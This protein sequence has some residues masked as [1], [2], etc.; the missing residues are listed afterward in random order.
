MHPEYAELPAPAH[1]PDQARAMLEEA[2][3][4]ET[5]IELTSISGDWRAV[6]SDAIASQL[7]DAG[8]KVKR[9]V[10]PGAT[11]WNNWTKYPFSTTDWGA[12]PL[13]VQVYALAYKSDSAWNE[14]GHANP[15]FDAKLEEAM[16]IYDA[17]AR[18][19]IMADLQAM[20][21]DS[22]AIIQPFWVNQTLHHVA[23]LKGYERHQAREMHFERAWLD[24]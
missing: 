9:T 14:S 10:V 21:Q 19:A 11:F 17:E 3:D 7:R 1:D 8:L 20:L 23:E 13:G 6:T 16:G 5:E 12:R 15:A 18:R 22:G 2:G 4:A 24:I